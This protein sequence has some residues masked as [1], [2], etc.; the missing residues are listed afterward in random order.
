M[1]HWYDSPYSDEKVPSVTTILSIIAKIWLMLW[2]AKSERRFCAKVLFEAFQGLRHFE[3]AEDVEAY[4][5]SRFEEEHGND[6]KYIA[7]VESKQA[8][9]LGSLVHG[10][11][12][13]YWQVWEKKEIE[14]ADW[15]ILPHEQYMAFLSDYYPTEAI[16]ML[17][18]Y[19]RCLRENNI[20]IL[21]TEQTVHHFEGFS[22]TL[23]M[24]A[25]VNGIKAIGDLKTGDPERIGPP[26]VPRYEHRLQLEA[27]RRCVKPE[28][29][30]RF[31]IYLRKDKFAGKYCFWFEDLN[32]QNE[33]DWQDFLA[34]KRL[35]NS[36]NRR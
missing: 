31:V 1:S 6:N 24:T 34:A 9:D 8:M 12:D 32:K 13:A 27:Y 19:F 5:A 21:S 14:E 30:G 28:P 10:M 18:A 11:V 29:T 25:R 23:D 16:K 35:F 15:V 7:Q 36:M 33:E 17:G 4:I 22:G 2:Y 3:S 26:A 20:I